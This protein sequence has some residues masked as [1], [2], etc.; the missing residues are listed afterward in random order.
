MEEFSGGVN[1][2]KASCFHVASESVV[3]CLL[4]YLWTAWCHFKAMPNQLPMSRP[5]AHRA[6]ISR[7]PFYDMLAARKKKVSSMKRH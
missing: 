5:C 2:V 7:D 1:G 3:D 4:F 6:A